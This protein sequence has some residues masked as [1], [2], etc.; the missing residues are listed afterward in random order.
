[1]LPDFLVLDP[2]RDSGTAH[3][4]ASAEK[5]PSAGSMFA[6]PVSW[7]ESN[8]SLRITFA[9][10]NGRAEYSLAINPDTLPGTVRQHVE[11]RNDEQLLFSSA[12]TTRLNAVVTPCAAL[13][14]SA[15]RS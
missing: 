6:G 8:D 7:F 1:M 14:S 10:R 12:D 5:T 13:P 11:L 3:V 15:L 2:G 4:A 9:G